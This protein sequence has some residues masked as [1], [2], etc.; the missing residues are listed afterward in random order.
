MY[1]I[2]Y[3]LKDKSIGVYYDMGMKLPSFYITNDHPQASTFLWADV[4]PIQQVLQLINIS[5]KYKLKQ[6]LHIC[7]VG[8]KFL[9]IFNTR[10]LIIMLWP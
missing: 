6:Y 9:C 7:K 10:A 5:Y 1:K 8:I 4:F 3:D 2:L